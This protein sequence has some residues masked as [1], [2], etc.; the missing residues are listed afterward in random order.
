[1]SAKKRSYKSTSR[2]KRNNEIEFLKEA[3]WAN[4]HAAEEGPKKKSWSTKDLK[5]IRP[6]TVAQEE[7]FQ[8]W[9][10]GKHL[11][12]SGSA[13][14]GKTFLAFY[15]ALNELF[16]QRTRRI[17]IV[18]SAVATRDLGF[19]PGTLEEK[20][21]QYE[22]PYHDILWE[23]IGRSSTYQDMKDAGLIEFMTTSFVRGL[24]WDNAI[25]IIDEGQN[26]TFHEINSIMT[27]IGENTRII[28]TGDIRQT[29]L[30]ESKKHLGTEG[31]SQALRVF[32]NMDS[33]ASVHFTKYDIVRS[34]FVKSWIVACEHITP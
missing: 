31:M 30:T 22:L 23:L 7:M 10:S 6:K 33:F 32:E 2:S 3:L 17:I 14:T 19:L 28:L 1:M 20:T 21:A 18:R 15:L 11:C 13:G 4:G 27:R 5:N 9:F 12:A 24:T 29:D 34:E 8:A 26:M 25:V 16:T